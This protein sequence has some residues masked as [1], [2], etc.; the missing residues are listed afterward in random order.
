MSILTRVSRLFKAD[1][2]GILDAMEDPE[3]TLRQAV[4]DMEE[5]IAKSEARIKRLVRKEDR[6]E[7]TK[8]S[9][10]RELQDLER[11]IGFCLDENNEMLAKSLIRKKLEVDQWLKRIAIQLGHV[12]DEKTIIS[13]ELSERK[14]KLKSITEKQGVFAVRSGNG[15]AEHSDRSLS[16]ERCETITEEQV[17]LEFLHQKQKCAKSTDCPS[18]GELK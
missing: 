15:W 16:T 11:E 2:H 14:D 7:K 18:S 13:E 1:M 3:A 6:L 8:K 12:N 4:R 5:E 9:F 17:E 10:A